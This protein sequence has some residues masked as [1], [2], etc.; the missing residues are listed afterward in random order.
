MA[1]YENPIC[2]APHQEDP[3]RRYCG[4]RM[5]LLGERH[6]LYQ[7]KKFVFECPRCGC[8]RAIDELAAERCSRRL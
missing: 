2:I 3:Q 5:R 1:R 6:P 4:V 7:P 8:I